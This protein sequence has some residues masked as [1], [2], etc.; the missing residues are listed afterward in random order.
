MRVWTFL[1]GEVEGEERVPR[2]MQDA[3]AEEAV[4]L[5]M[6]YLLLEAVP[7]HAVLELRLLMVREAEAEQRD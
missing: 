2:L 7:G 3:R 4:W 6:V 1:E 5:E